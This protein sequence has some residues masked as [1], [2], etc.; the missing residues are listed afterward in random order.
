M[1]SVKLFCVIIMIMICFDNLNGEVS[2]Q[3]AVPNAAAIGARHFIKIYYPES[4]MSFRAA[5]NVKEAIKKELSQ[6]FV[7][8]DYTDGKLDKKFIIKCF[9][10]YENAKINLKGHLIWEKLSKMTL[11]KEK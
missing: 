5:Q 11:P 3:L 7:I 9:E 6:F 4:T 2:A 8:Y 10:S 1:K